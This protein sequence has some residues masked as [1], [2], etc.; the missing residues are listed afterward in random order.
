MLATVK[1][2][3][4]HWLGVLKQAV[5]FW[6]DSNAFANAGSLAFFTLFSIAPV[7]IVIVSIIGFVFG[8]E[9]A[10][11]QIAAQLQETLGP[12][13]AQAVQ[14]AV[15]KSSLKGG[16]L[17]A[18]VTGVLAMLLG[19]TTVFGQMQ[20]SLN[21][22]WTVAPK[23]SRN[24]IFLLLRKRITSLTI[25]LAVGFVMLV[26]LSMSVGLRI[27]LHNVQ[28]WLPWYDVAFSALDTV[29]S[30]LVA[31]LLFATIFKILPDVKLR[32]KDVALGSLIT[33]LLFTVGRVLIALYL[34]NTAT[35]STYGAAGSLVLLLL[36]VNYSSLILLFGAAFIR[37]HL[38]SRGL[39]VR[40]RSVA[41]RFHR[42][43][44]E[45]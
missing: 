27:L 5:E 4:R 38:R 16:G 15:A 2:F 34:S 33:A 11:G 35:A 28:G 23:P 42:E 43:I 39:P 45:D 19:A 24:S 12:E 14:T 37:A 8:Q 7:V 13:A 26:S 9:A 25:V 3:T 36:W 31:S 22:I 29:L 6:L 44:I 41:V 21:A 17:L 10:E 20:N 32:W 1:Q 30:I 40:P 18:T